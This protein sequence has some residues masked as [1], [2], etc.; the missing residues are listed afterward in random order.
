M[1][2]RRY[3]KTCRTKAHN[4]IKKNPIFLYQCGE[5]GLPLNIVTENEVCFFSSCFPRNLTKIILSTYPFFYPF[6]FLHHS[7]YNA[8][9]NI[10]LPRIKLLLKVESFTLLKMVSILCSIFLACTSYVR[11][12]IGL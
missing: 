3:F 12:F 1:I 4:S 11:L 10:L 7:L 6:F 5:E 8:T 9:I 2:V